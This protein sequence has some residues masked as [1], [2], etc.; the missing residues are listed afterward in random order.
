MTVFGVDMT[1]LLM[2]LLG[3]VTTIL[4]VLGFL[5]RYVIP[6]GLPIAKVVDNIIVWLFGA[7]ILLVTLLVLHQIY[8][9]TLGG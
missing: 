7:N 1:S 9:K 6:E 5:D 2:Y 8:I 3:C 4:I